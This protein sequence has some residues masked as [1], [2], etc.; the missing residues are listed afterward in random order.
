MCVLFAAR[1]TEL[2]ECVV[3]VEYGAIEEG[4]L[5][6]VHS[7]GFVCA[8]SYNAFVPTLL[9]VHG[10]DRGRVF[11]LPPDE[12]QLVG[13]SSEALGLTDR[14]ISRLHAELTPD[15]DRWLVRDLGSSH[16]TFL[17]GMRTCGHAALSLGDRLRLGDSEFLVIDESVGH[18]TVL[19]DAQA[20]C[21]STRISPASP[22][23]RDARLAYKL[24]T[25][26]AE[27][28]CADDFLR[29]AAHAIR[30]AAGLSHCTILRASADG[31]VA[32]MGIEHAPLALAEEA[33]A[34]GE[35]ILAQHAVAIP[36]VATNDQTPAAVLV[37]CGDARISNPST[38][39]LLALAAQLVG[40]GLAAR[41]TTGGMDGR[42]AALGESMATLS[43][44]I[45]NILQGLRS[46]ADA[47]EM[48]LS[49]GEIGHAREGWPILQRNL[50]RIQ[51]LVLNMLAWAK[52]RPLEPEMIDLNALVTEV[53]ELLSA[54]AARK[55]IRLL[56][57]LDEAL[58]P[59]HA[60]MSAIYQAVTNLAVNAIEAVSEKVGVVTIRTRYLVD[61]D[62]VEIT[63]LDNGRGIPAALRARLFEPFHSTKGQR[64]TGLGL[65]VTRKIAERHGGSAQLLRSDEHGSEIALTIKASPPADDDAHNLND[66]DATRAPRRAQTGDVPWTFGP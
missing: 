53:R 23:G 20:T 44:A 22:E 32:P 33:I 26:S 63:V 8:N 55:R 35:A 45:K 10:P 47:V 30:D 2:V 58:P 11:P 3:Q 21:A 28:T 43:H 14:T 29:E 51:S 65:A 24:A 37:A 19:D 56:V 52:E 50:D 5:P 6:R 31:L 39:A 40:L 36:L 66:L 38:L 42:L 9:A 27:P 46:G 1:S 7:T 59:A 62:A 18:A 41:A 60:D 16:G 54:A 61:E 48:S 15:G 12:P 13:R 4:V 57:E 34:T 17:N 49:R 25:L 64:G